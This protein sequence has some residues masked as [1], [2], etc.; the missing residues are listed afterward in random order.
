MPKKTLTPDPVAP[1][2]KPRIS[3]LERRLQNPFGEASAPIALKDATRTPR[4]FNS[5]I[6]NDKI[7]RA[8]H[9]GW[10]HVMVTDVLD[11][12]QI[13]GYN[14]SPEGYITRGERGQ[15]YLMSMPTQWVQAIAM[16]KTQKNNADMGDATKT[17]ASV[18]Q[19]ASEQ[20]GDQP[21]SYLDKHFGMVGGVTDTI[22]RV[23]R[24]PEE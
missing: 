8:K 23:E 19:A 12:A 4:W 10:D 7:W 14:K 3:V 15:E 11:L 2:V 20:L 5:A 18:V 9:N 16:A 22:E 24:T 1:P 13:G 6:I 21:A 17:K